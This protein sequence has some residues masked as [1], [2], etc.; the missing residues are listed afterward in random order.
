MS[1]TLDVEVGMSLVDNAFL[2]SKINLQ[3]LKHYQH[4]YGLGYLAGLPY[5]PMY[6]GRDAAWTLLGVNSIGDFEASKHSLNLLARYQAT[7]DGEDNW[8]VPFYR[9]EVPHEIRTDGTIIYYSVDATP[10]FVIALHDYYK[11]SG[12]R[13]F[14]QYLYDNVV[15][16][17]DWSW[18]QIEMVMG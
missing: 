13:L 9:G 18:R 8:R 3:L 6:F 14:L 2:N 7:V 16:A 15:K 12:D 5:F 11:W 10:L 17:M 4:G 1:D